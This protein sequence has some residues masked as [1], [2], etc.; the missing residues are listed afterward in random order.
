M[1]KLIYRITPIMKTNVEVALLL[2]RN[3]VYLERTKT[4]RK[5]ITLIMDMEIMCI[6]IRVKSTQMKIIIK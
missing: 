1:E 4:P 3:I 6:L 2:K 5:N